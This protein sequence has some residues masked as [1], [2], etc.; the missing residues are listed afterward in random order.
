VKYENTSLAYYNEKRHNKEKII[1]SIIAFGIG[2]FVGGLAGVFI[3]L[4]ITGGSAEPSQAISAPTLAAESFGTPVGIMEVE[5]QVAAMANSNAAP[6][7]PETTLEPVV[8]RIV[9]AESEARFSV[10]ET[11]PVGTAVGRTREIAGDVYVDFNTPSNS[12]LGTIR[13]NLRTLVTDDPD[14]DKSIRCCV[15]LTARSEYEFADFVPIQISGY[16]EQ[17][18]FGQPNEGQITGNLTLRGVTQPVT[19]NVLLTVLSPEELRGLASAT[20][21]RSDFSII[22]D[23]DNG[24]DYHG[25]A[26]EIALEFEFIARP[27]P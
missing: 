7:Q 19:F 12:Q 24:F 5:D 14:R 23:A 13:V 27:A 11:F 2:A 6:D 1:Y 22:N 10:Y 26:E 21:M 4:N 17:I 16:P 9:S 8:Y 3:F 25:V 15:L 18:V 20:V